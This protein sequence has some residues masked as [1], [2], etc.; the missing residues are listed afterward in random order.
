VLHSRRN[1]DSSPD[2]RR[3]I[4]FNDVLPSIIQPAV[5]QQKSKAAIGQIY[6][7]IFL[8]SIRHERN[9]RAVLRAMPE[10]AIHPT[11]SLNVESISV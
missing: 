9:T 8:D 1:I 2:V 10:R 3:V 5:A 11:P 4:R 7:M 6:L